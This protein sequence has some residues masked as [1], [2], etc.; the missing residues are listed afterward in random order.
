V[1]LFNFFATSR[2]RDVAQIQPDIAGLLDVALSLMCELEP[3]EISE[4]NAVSNRDLLKS[5]CSLLSQGFLAAPL[6]S[7]RHFKLLEK[8]VSRPELYVAQLKQHPE[9]ESQRIQVG[10]CRNLPSRRR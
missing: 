9:A 4:V 8:Y 10:A 2:W 5:D 7:V 6:C 3:D 1:Q